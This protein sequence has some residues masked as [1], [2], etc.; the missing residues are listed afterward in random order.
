MKKVIFS[1]LL[2]I[3]L[4]GVGFS[5]GIYIRV[6]SGYGLPI[7]TGS[8]GQKLLGTYIST[9]ALTSNSNI[10][11][12][13]KA[14]YG[15]GPDFS[16]AFGYKINANF[17][18]DVN[19]QYLLGNRFQTS[20]IRNYTYDTYTSLHSD[21]QKSYAM[22]FL[23]NPSIIFSA[24]FGKH[25]PYARFGLIAGVPSMTSTQSYFDDGDGTVSFTKEWQYSKGRAL[26]YQAA[27]GMDWK[28]S[29]KLDIFTELNFTSLTYYAGEKTLKSYINAGVD[30]MPNLSLNQKQTVYKTSLDSYTSYDSSK[31]AIDLQKPMP[32]SSASLQIGI[33]LQ[34]WKKAD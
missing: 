24:G 6:G 16:F 12:D 23:F 1:S 2:V 5:Q 22:G 14:S 3:M 8:I 15:A 9:T 18:L 17:I 21:I 31:P 11:K 7:S 28:L 26:G 13:V 25:A 10:A 34:L 32:F 30:I 27:V 4:S 19:V 29:E 20:D 33:R